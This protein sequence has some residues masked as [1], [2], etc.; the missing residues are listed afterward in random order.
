MST[1][2]DHVYQMRAG[3]Y[4]VVSGREY[5]PWAMREYA[6][7]GMQVEQRRASRRKARILTQEQWGAIVADACA[8][9]NVG[10]IFN[11]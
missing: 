9:A 2:K 1:L 3:W 8:S 10:E 6:V 11:A 5:G 7:A 4:C